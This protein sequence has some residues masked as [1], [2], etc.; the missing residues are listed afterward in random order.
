MVEETDADLAA[1]FTAQLRPDSIYVS[2]SLAALAQDPGLIDE[3]ANPI[4]LIHDAVVHAAMTTRQRRT[5][6][7]IA[8]VDLAAVVEG[9]STAFGQDDYAS[10][11][12]RL[13]AVDGFVHAITVAQLYG[14]DAPVPARP[15]RGDS[16]P[17]AYAAGVKAAERHVVP[18]VRDLLPFRFADD[19][20][21]VLSCRERLQEDGE[22]LDEIGWEIYLH[23]RA[24]GGDHHYAVNQATDGNLRKRLDVR[25]DFVKRS[26]RRCP[27]AI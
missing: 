7:M 24:R 20:A 15:W 13:A 8:L 19:K 21:T 17:D 4:R 16:E 2:D 10:D 18:Y 11:W 23:V 5:R 12:R 22:Q 25:N 9:V 1:Q 27:P 14:T 26:L 6:L 3:L